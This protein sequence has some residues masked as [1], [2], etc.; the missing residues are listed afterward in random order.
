[1]S[2]P[3][4]S[5]TAES[6]YAEL[7]QRFD[8]LTKI[9]AAGNEAETRLKIIDEILFEVLDWSKAD[10]EVEKFCR[11]KGYADYVCSTGETVALVLEAK[12]AEIAFTIPSAKFKCEPVCFAL[13]E[14]ECKEA[15]QALRQAQG[16]AASLGSR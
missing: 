12:R 5:W 13:V 14:A 15:G 9:T 6:A 2:E 3:V 10:V 4:A 1:M 16:Y 8:E 11:E 7:L